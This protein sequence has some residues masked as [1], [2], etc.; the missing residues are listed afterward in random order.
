MQQKK[1]FLLIN[2][3]VKQM[4]KQLKYKIRRL[5]FIYIPVELIFIGIFILGFFAAY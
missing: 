2:K 5:I 1:E 4:K 3:E